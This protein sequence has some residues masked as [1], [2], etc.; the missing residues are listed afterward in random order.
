[1]GSV[2]SFT[3]LYGQVAIYFCGWLAA[4]LQQHLFGGLILLIRQY[5][6]WFLLANWYRREQKIPNRANGRLW[7]FLMRQVTY[8]FEGH[9]F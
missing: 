1:M 7:R 3:K 6:Y 4:R 9:P 8:T 5:Q 2:V